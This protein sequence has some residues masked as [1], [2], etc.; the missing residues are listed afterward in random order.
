MIYIAPGQEDKLSILSNTAGSRDFESF[1]SGLGWEV[2]DC[3]RPITYE[4]FLNIQPTCFIVYVA[5]HDI[6]VCRLT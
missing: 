3:S 1:V 4:F 2:S 5:N 6:F